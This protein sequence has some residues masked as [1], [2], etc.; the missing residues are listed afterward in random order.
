[1]HDL[2]SFVI[3]RH[4]VS[5]RAIRSTL[6]AP[7]IEA[8]AV[9]IRELPVCDSETSTQAINVERAFAGMSYA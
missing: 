3:E 8:Q 4:W 7:S 5:K 1:M 9:H 6:V 2:E